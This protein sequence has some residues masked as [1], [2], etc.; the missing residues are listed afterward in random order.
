LL[1]R[2]LGEGLAK[3]RSPLRDRLLHTGRA[4]EL[5]A[6]LLMTSRRK[7][8]D[9]KL[10]VGERAEAVRTLALAKFPDI[11]LIVPDLLDTRHPQALQLAAVET[12]SRF[13]D[14]A[15]GNALIGAWAGFSP[16]V[17]AA[18]AEAIFSRA[19]WASLFLA[20]VERK[21]IPATDIDPGRLKVLEGH[22]NPAVGTQAARVAKLLKLGRRADVVKA[23]EK[24]LTMKGDA[25]RGKALFEKVCAACHR[26]EGVGHEIGPNLAALQNRGAETILLNVLDPNR[27]VNPQYMNYVVTTK[28][29]RQ[30]TGMVAAETATSVTLRRG[31]DLSD[32]ILRIDIDRMRSTGLSLMP[33]GLEQQVDRQGMADL[34]AYLLGA[35]G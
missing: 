16:K 31:E 6:D 23:Y 27:E 32:T 14:A 1:V 2:S 17:R 4:A 5:L 20:A 18:A 8:A 3:S 22:S 19:E 9:E 21:R 35:K 11:Q 13:P 29:G 34:I 12:L 28:D 33:E 7:A 24:A 10:A 15:A 30:F 26:M 25:P